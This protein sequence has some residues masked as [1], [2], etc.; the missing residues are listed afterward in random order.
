MKWYKNVTLDNDFYIKGQAFKIQKHVNKIFNKFS[1][2][3]D[4]TQRETTLFHIY[5]GSLCCNQVYTMESDNKITFNGTS[6]EEI[7]IIN[8]LKK[9][10]LKLVK[11]NKTKI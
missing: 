8:S 1:N 11:K 7:A 3:S 6:V 5:I 9:F 2:N 4:L 10:R